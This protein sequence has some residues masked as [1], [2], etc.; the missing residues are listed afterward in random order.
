MSEPMSP[1]DKVAG[2]RQAV[3]EKAQSRVEAN[4]ESM[5]SK[6][7]STSGWFKRAGESFGSGINAV[8]E[9]T[10]GLIDRAKEKIS[11]VQEK[12]D[13]G[14]TAAKEKVEG[15]GEWVGDQA[16]NLR[17]TR[18][19]VDTFLTKKVERVMDTGLAGLQKLVE[20]DERA[21]TTFETKSKEIFARGRERISEM[22]ASRKERKAQRLEDR[23]KRLQQRALAVVQAAKS[24]ID[25]YAKHLPKIAKKAGITIEVKSVDYSKAEIFREAVVE[26]G[27]LMEK[28]EHYK[29]TAEGLKVEAEQMREEAGQRRVNGD[30]LGRIVY[31]IIEKMAYGGDKPEWANLEALPEGSEEE[32]AGAD[33]AQGDQAGQTGNVSAQPA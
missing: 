24:E 23:A 31:I 12:A 8:R 7:E 22:G 1:S 30:E 27:S 28:A 20:I 4:Q 15:A 16:E 10:N 11:Q 6:K 26:A 13:S 2:M 18:D 14:L 33:D 29:E 19:K 17:G 21:A 32:E 5:E 3:G 25:A 9:K